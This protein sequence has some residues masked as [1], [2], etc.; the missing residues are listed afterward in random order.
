MD[1]TLFFDLQKNRFFFF[2][3]GMDERETEKTL[4]KMDVIILYL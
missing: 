4:R 3:Q 2:D 1:A